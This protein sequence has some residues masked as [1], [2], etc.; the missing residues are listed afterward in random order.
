MSFQEATRPSLTS[1]T[2]E[3]IQLLESGNEKF[4]SQNSHVPP[5]R[6]LL[7]PRI[8]RSLNASPNHTHIAML[9]LSVF[10][11]LP[12]PPIPLCSHHAAARSLCCSTS[13]ALLSQPINL[14]IPTSERN[15]SLCRTQ[16]TAIGV[17]TSFPPRTLPPTKRNAGVA[18]RRLALHARSKC[19]RYSAA[20]ILMS[21]F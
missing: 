1:Q 14:S 18:A 19:T 20:K 9:V 4:P 15:N 17:V 12:L 21:N 11:R 8:H 13:A 7:L 3:R 6:T 5:V 16:Q 10:S 2:A